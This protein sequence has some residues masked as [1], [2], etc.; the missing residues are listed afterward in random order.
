[1]EVVYGI[2]A[3]LVVVAHFAYV[4][5][6]ILG[7]LAVLIGRFLGWNWTR[8]FWFRAVHLAMIAIVVAEAW[9]GIT[10]PLTNWENSLRALAG[11]AAWMSGL[12][13]D[14]APSRANAPIVGRDLRG[15]IKV[16]PLANWTAAD[17]D[18]Y[19]ARHDV[20]VNPLTLQ[21][22]PSIGCMPCTKP[23]APGEDPRSGRW[24]GRD[25][26]ECGLH[27]S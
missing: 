9:M 11:K 6:V 1:M 21:G 20:P 15:L 18:E 4:L 13:R 22:Y 7:L 3:D 10:C 26:T 19:I 2:L 12:R 8:K 5:F 24:S 25:K 16:N 27:V 14:E 23:V 17:V